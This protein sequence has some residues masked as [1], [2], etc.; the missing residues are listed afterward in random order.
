MPVLW[1]AGRDE[2]HRLDAFVPENGTGG[3]ASGP[4]PVLTKRQ[5]IRSSTIGFAVN[6]VPAGA[7]SYADFSESSA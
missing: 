2:S 6:S 1:T 3:C 4:V 7:M 5:A